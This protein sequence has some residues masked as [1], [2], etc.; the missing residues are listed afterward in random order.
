MGAFFGIEEIGGEVTA[1][2]EDSYKKSA[3][4]GRFGGDC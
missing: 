3:H 1:C 4:C 2:R